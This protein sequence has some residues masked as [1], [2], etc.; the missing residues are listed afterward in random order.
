L[1]AC[2]I[3][4]V[5]VAQSPITHMSGSIGNESVVAVEK[6]MTSRGY[7]M[8]PFLSG[9]AIRH[10]AVREPGMRWLIEQY[11][12]AQKI[13][14][15]VLNFLLHGGNLT[16]STARENTR[17]IAEMKTAWPLLALIGGSLKNQILSGNLDAW[18]GRLICEENRQWIPELPEQR[19][20][21]A[22]QWIGN[23]QYTRSDAKKLGI[24]K[25]LEQEPTKDEKSNLM[26]MGGQCVNAGAMFIHGF[27]IRHATP[28]ETGALLWSLRLWQAAGSTIGG[29]AAK[30]HG[31]L[32]CELIGISQKQQDKLCE[33]Y[34]EHAIA[35]KDA[36]IA[37]LGEAW[38]C[39]ID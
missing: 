3:H 39:K 15:K 17:L 38:G 36:A 14:L 1:S 25:E 12:L 13:D 27:V 30:G 29:Q 6:V 24:S 35:Q 26:I 18:R 20:H 7:R 33:Q 34:V 21:S 4:C 19:I 11:G 2:I 9:N 31:R 22:E 28:L 23:F 32:K 16:E 5:S 37:W 8:V 10:R